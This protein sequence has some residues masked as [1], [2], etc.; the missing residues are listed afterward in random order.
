M[1]KLD[2]ILLAAGKGTRT[3]LPLAKQFLHLS[4]I[5]VIIHA[6]RPFER[7]AIVDRKIIAAPP[8]SLSEVA[9]L[10]EQ[11]T[12]TNFHVIPGGTSRQDSVR[13]ALEHVRTERVLTHNAALPF[14][15]EE[16]IERV[17]EHHDPCVTTVTPMQYPLCRGTTFASETVDMTDLNIINTPQS[18]DTHLFRECHRLA[19]SEQVAFRTDCELMM[20]YGH[21]VRFVKGDPS[22]FKITTELDVV[23]AEALMQRRTDPRS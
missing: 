4:G 21:A 19:M 20:K 3:T 9:S 22:N 6:L 15:T 7:L 16:M 23:T 5:P 2:L 18:F 10:L 8:D 1:S 12:I 17:A 14:V 13:R 11:H